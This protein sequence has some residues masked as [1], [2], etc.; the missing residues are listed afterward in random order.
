[1]AAPTIKWR[2]CGGSASSVSYSSIQSLDFGTVTA[3]AWSQFK[4][5][6][7][8]VATNS[9]QSCKWWLSDIGAQRSSTSESVGTGAGWIHKFTF[10]ASAPVVCSATVASATPGT[11][12]PESSGSAAS[13]NAVA[14]AA[15]GDFIALFLKVASAAGDGATTAWGYQLK[16]SY[17]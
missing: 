15:Y 9:I 11:E 8:A 3:G 12:S 5:V 10:N 14:P 1:M 16:Y 4:V 7:P 17:T 2:L 13:Y 6:Q